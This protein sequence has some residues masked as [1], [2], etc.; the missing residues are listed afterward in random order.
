MNTQTIVQERYFNP[1]DARPR[2]PAIALARFAYTVA[3]CLVA[4]MACAALLTGSIWAA[5]EPGLAPYLQAFNWSASFVFLAIALEA[6]KSST[7]SMA[8]ASGIA[9]LMLT[10]LSTRFGLELALWGTVLM[11]AWLSIAIIRR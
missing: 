3:R 10:G 8:F 7:A 9:I 4:I 11:C 6:R 2:G 1:A 5:T